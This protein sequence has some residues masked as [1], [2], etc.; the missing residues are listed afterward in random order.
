MARLLSDCLLRRRKT[1]KTRGPIQHE[2]GLTQPLKACR[3]D[4]TKPK[5]G[6]GQ[7]MQRTESI[8]R[9]SFHSPFPIRFYSWVFTK[10]FCEE[11]RMTFKPRITT[12]LRPLSTQGFFVNRFCSPSPDQKTEE[13]RR[14]AHWGFI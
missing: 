4:D 7:G 8:K 9:A 1:D 13:R 10:G 5:P 11:G 3:S 2:A 12:V 14:G 6:V